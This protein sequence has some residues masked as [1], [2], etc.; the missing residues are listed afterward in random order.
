MSNPEQDLLWRA[1]SDPTRRRIL[2][3]LREGPRSTGELCEAF[4]TS[5]YAVMKHLGVL[6]EARLVTVR[7]EG[8]V[9]WNHL[10]AVPLQEVVAR[11]L[12]PYES[13]WASNLIRLR[14]AAESASPEP[15]E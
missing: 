3:L 1:L 10:N 13:M 2:D 9:R 14:D 7:R 15:E 6:V 8:R 4:D 12:T 5:R 11:W